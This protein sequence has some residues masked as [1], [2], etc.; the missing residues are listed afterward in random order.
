MNYTKLQKELYINRLI[1]REFK[2]ERENLLIH[3]IQN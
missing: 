1:A 3:D 2:K